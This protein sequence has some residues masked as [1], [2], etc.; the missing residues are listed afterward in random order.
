MVVEI[1]EAVLLNE[2]PPVRDKL[3]ALR[4]AGVQLAVDDFGTAYAALAYLKNTRSII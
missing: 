2:A 4:R 1:T 3:D